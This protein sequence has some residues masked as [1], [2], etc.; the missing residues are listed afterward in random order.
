M[1]TVMKDCERPEVGPLQSGGHHN[2]PHRLQKYT[3]KRLDA[4]VELPAPCSP[5]LRELFL[6]SPLPVPLIRTHLYLDSGLIVLNG[7][8]PLHSLRRTNSIHQE[9][10]HAQHGAHW[11]IDRAELSE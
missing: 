4:R 3:I 2:E 7:Q 1:F 10:A 9:A 8:I 6:V 11:K 5:L